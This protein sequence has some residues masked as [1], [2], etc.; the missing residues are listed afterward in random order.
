[1]KAGLLTR[2]GILLIIAPLLALGFHY[3][4]ELITVH[5]CLQAG[6]SFDYTTMSCGFT[7][8]YEYIP[9]SVRYRW[10]LNIALGVSLFG[11]LLSVV[12]G[13]KRRRLPLREYSAGSERGATPDAAARG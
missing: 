6:G 12:G 10:N 8:H 4:S 5:R 11:L 9:Y 2:I 7:D 1:M 3:F 13:A